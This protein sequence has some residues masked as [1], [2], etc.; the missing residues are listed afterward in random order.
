MN[1]I[2]IISHFLFEKT[3]FLFWQMW[4]KLK[5]PFIKVNQFKC[6]RL[7][8]FL[9]YQSFFNWSIV[10]LQC[11]VSF[12]YSKVI[13]LY[14][15][16]LFQILFLYIRGPQPPGHGPVPLC[17]LLGTGPHSTVGERQ[18][19][20]WNFICIYS[21][22]PSLTLLPELRLLSALWWVV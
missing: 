4:I 14:I 20:E 10:D 16:I 15:Y 13:Q 6:N 18:A 3:T 22:T 8:F 11:C 21:R 9:I 7:T 19:S 5:L 17:D 12:R 1:T 2:L